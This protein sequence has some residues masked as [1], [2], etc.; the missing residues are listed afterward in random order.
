M[1]WNSNN[2]AKVRKERTV[3][4]FKTKTEFK[5]PNSVKTRSKSLK[6]SGSKDVVETVNIKRPKTQNC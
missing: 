5:K 4:F 3:T 2:K 1:K 6:K